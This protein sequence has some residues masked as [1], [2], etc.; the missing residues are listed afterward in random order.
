MSDVPPL[1]TPPTPSASIW[2]TESPPLAPIPPADFFPVITP[3]EGGW[4]ALT[5]LTMQNVVSAIALRLWG[6]PLGVALLLSFLSTALLF[7]LTMRRT[8][9]ALFR[10]SRWRTRPKWGVAL[11]TFGLAFVASRALLVFVLSLWPQG[12]QTVPEFLSKGYDVWVLLLVAGVLIPVAEEVAFRGLLMRGLEWARG[13]L[14]AAL[15]SSLLFGLAHGA[16]AQVIAILP[17]AWLMARAVQHSGSLWTSV[18]VHVLNNALA[19]GLG[20]L[21]QGR[22]LSALGGDL[23]GVKIPLGLGVAGLLIGAAALVIGTLWLTPRPAIVS[24]LSP[25]RLPVWT[26]STLLLAVLV[27]AAVVISSAPLFLKAGRFSGL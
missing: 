25:P 22:D 10:D 15:L 14:F 1:K 27:L 7:G 9:A 17:L 18:T 26:L 24:P 8:A 13:P 20:A 4:A 21:L 12:A 23:S 2:A 19:V 6:L 16:P 11:G 3:A 5:V